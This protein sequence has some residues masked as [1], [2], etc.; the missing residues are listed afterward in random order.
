MY[1]GIIQMFQRQFAD[2]EPV[3]A[4]YEDQKQAQAVPIASDRAR[5]QPLV[6]RQVL[7]EVA[8]NDR[9]KGL[10]RHGAPPP[11]DIGAND[12]KR[13]L[14]ASSSSLVMVRYTAVLLG[15]TCPR[16]VDR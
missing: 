4:G 7:Q 16:N 15:L 14:A 8:V 12:S 13:W 5:L 2:A 6:S 11:D 10:L 3:G 1:G 9:R